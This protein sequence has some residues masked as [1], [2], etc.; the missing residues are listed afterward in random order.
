LP[1]GLFINAMVAAA[2]WLQAGVPVRFPDVRIVMTEG[3]TGWVPL[4]LDQLRYRNRHEKSATNRW[5]SKWPPPDEIL[6][7]N[8]WFTTFY[9]PLTLKLRHDIG[10]DKIMFESDYPHSD[11]SWPDSQEFLSSQVATFPKEDIELMAWKN[12]SKLYRHVIK[13]EH[14]PERF[15]PRLG[16]AR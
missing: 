9:N 11:S 2:D 12:A 6:R 1:G 10:I 8:F 15:R 13:P 3:G 4:L 7:R 5:P 14:L 16:E